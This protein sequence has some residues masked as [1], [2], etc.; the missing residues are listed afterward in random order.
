[1][2]ALFMKAKYKGPS[3]G[4]L[5]SCTLKVGLDSQPSVH[6]WS[7]WLPNWLYIHT[8]IQQR[9]ITRQIALLSCICSAFI[10]N[11]RSC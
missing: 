7:L 1:M 8:Q 10:A 6:K 3:K 5:D 9:W 11:F 2:R 4:P